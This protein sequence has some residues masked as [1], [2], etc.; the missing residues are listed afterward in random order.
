MGQRVGAFIIISSK[1]IQY[2][3]TN[4]SEPS[5]PPPSS[6]QQYIE[7]P[8]GKGSKSSLNI[9][10]L[11]LIGG[12]GYVMFRTF[13]MEERINDLIVLVK[14]KTES[15]R[16]PSAR[17]ATHR[18]LQR[19]DEQYSSS[20]DEHEDKE[21]GMDGEEEYQESDEDDVR[22]EEQPRA[23]DPPP[24]QV[25]GTPPPP[26]TGSAFVTTRQRRTG[27]ELRRNVR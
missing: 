19:P 1:M 5:R 25:E 27:S 24:K 10:N 23:P 8:V 22:I 14:R 21:D 12:L 20:S 18:P 16:I 4:M 11:V 7:V 9:G 2:E 13:L 3:K 6:Q 26:P 15:P 17:L